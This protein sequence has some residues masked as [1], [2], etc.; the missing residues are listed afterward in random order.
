[1]DTMRQSKIEQFSITVFR[2]N[3]TDIDGSTAVL[4]EEEFFDSL[5][6][7]LEHADWMTVR[8]IKQ[9]VADVVD[10]RIAKNRLADQ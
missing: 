8:T 7:M 3:I 9:R 10:D 5:I 2:Y 4:S 6:F 1:M